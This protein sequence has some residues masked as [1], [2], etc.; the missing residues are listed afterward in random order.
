MPTVEI[1]V[2]IG[3][4]EAQSR[5]GALA[6]FSWLPA[7]SRQVVASVSG[8]RVFAHVQ[9]RSVRNSFQ[10]HFRG[11]LEPTSEGTVLRGRI[12]MHPFVILF[13]CI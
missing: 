1:R 7:V 4:I 9:R 13:M 10:P 5:I 11:R 3:M 12:G 2:P 6:R 8:T